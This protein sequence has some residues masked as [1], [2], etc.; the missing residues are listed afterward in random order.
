M[1]TTSVITFILCIVYFCSCN[2]TRSET[3]STNSLTDTTSLALSNKAIKY[4]FENKSDSV[5]TLLP[6]HNL[7]D[8]K[9]L[10]DL[11]KRIQTAINKYGYPKKESITVTTSTSK[12][13]FGTETTETFTYPFTDKDGQT[14]LIVLVGI[15][16]GKIHAI[17]TSLTLFSD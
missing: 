2:F 13:L 11:T 16:Q 5:L 8:K 14:K 1:K 9:N 10:P 17:N 6:S 12:S 4:I 15:K 3:N 7:F